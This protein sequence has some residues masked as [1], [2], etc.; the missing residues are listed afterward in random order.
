M[1]KEI[2]DKNS[3]KDMTYPKQTNKWLQHATHKF[4]IYKLYSISSKLYVGWMRSKASQDD[5][6]RLPAE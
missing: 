5:H 2:D 3:A 6:L 1:M 4:H